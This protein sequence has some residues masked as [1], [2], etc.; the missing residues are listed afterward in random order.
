M[1]GS[2]FGD[3]SVA[4]AGLALMVIG[5][6]LSGAAAD[7]TVVF[8]GRLISG[9][10]AVLLDVLLS[11]MT[12][13]WFADSEVVGGLTLTRSKLVLVSLAGTIWASLNVSYILLVS[14][15]PRF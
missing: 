6:A 14:F 8:A 10:G 12:S 4:L 15:A 3:K 7:Y 1:L 9:I 13:D 11:K 5:G 2:R